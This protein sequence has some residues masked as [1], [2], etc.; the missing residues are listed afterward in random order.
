MGY[1]IES[2]MEH[3]KLTGQRYARYRLVEDTR[4]TA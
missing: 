3:N 4:K 1:R 2:V